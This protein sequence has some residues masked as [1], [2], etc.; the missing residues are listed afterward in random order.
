MYLPQTTINRTPDTPSAQRQVESFTPCVRQNDRFIDPSGKPLQPGTVIICD[1]I[2]F[3]V[4]NNGEIYN[5]TGLVSLANSPSTFSHIINSIISLL[6]WFGRKQTNDN[7]ANEKQ[8]Q[9]IIET[10]NTEAF[11]NND[12]AIL[13]DSTDTLQ[14]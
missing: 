11:N 3:I 4:S 14:M 10:P 6:P 1:K 2:P 12:N 9:T 7:I 8:I 13:N 5:F